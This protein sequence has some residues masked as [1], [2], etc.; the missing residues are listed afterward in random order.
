VLEQTTLAGGGNERRTGDEENL[1]TV[2]KNRLKVL[3]LLRIEDLGVL[4]VTVDD[5][6]E[7][8]SYIVQ[9]DV[10]RLPQKKGRVEGKTHGPTT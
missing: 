3:D 9:W 8:S 5:I 1:N 10:Q 7:R 4:T 2:V 6:T